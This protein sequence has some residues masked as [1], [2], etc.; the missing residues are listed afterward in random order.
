MSRDGD[1]DGACALL[2]FWGTTLRWF[3]PAGHHCISAK[4]RLGGFGGNANVLLLAGRNVKETW[5]SNA[6]GASLGREVG[7]CCLL[8]E[9]GLCSGAW[10]W[11]QGSVRTLS[12]RNRGSGCPPEHP[13]HPSE[14]SC[15]L[16]ILDRAA[17]VLFPA[18]VAPLQAQHSK[19]R[20][21]GGSSLWM[22][23]NALTS[24][25]AGRRGGR[26]CVLHPKFR[27]SWNWDCCW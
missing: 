10:C 8:A 27:T 4:A 6:A 13:L 25:A 17:Q 14:F 5:G 9:P 12:H 20:E 2:A 15:L 22:L 18:S 3:V 1:G 26:W 7:Q 21:K 11:L 19:E 23:W 24:Q 16:S